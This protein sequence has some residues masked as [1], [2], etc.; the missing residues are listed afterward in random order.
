ARRPQQTQR[1]AQ[2]GLRNAPAERPTR[3]P[4]NDPQVPTCTE[5]A[6]RCAQHELKPRHHHGR[7]PLTLVRGCGQAGAT[8]A[9]APLPVLPPATPNRALV[10][11]KH[12][13]GRASCRERGQTW[14]V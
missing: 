9:I 14:E 10:C 12:Q 6:E 5:C 3:T 2:P 4:P 13:I 8:P 1:I 7:P 11:E